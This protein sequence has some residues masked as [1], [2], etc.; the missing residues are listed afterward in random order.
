MQDI[1]NM[2]ESQKGT[3]RAFRTIFPN[4]PL[5][6]GSLADASFL[7]MILYIATTAVILAVF[8][9]P[10]L[11]NLPPGCPRHERNHQRKRILSKEEVT[12]TVKSKNPVRTYAMI[13]WKNCTAHRPGS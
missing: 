12:R 10:R 8:F 1:M 7:K 11:E 2:M 13:E 9:R 4:L 3:L 6:T 5:M